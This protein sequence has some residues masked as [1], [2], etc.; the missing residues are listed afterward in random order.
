MEKNKDFKSILTFYPIGMQGYP[1]K[2]G[3]QRAIPNKFKLLPGYLKDL[4]YSTHLIGK[5]HVGYYAPKYT[6]ANRGFDTFFGYYNGYIRYFNHTITELQYK[7]SLFILQRE[8]KDRRI[9]ITTIDR[10]S[11]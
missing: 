11:F 10:S 8:R 4:G 6:P 2:A 1:L 5:W 3:E 9:E 7:V